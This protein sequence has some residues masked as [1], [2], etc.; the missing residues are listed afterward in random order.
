MFVAT[1]AIVGGVVGAQAAASDPNARDY[2][3]GYAAGHAAGYDVGKK[4]GGAILLGTLGVSAI[5]S[6]TIPFTGVL[7][8]CRRKTQP[9]PLPAI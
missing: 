2:K 1:L 9:P 8:W 5:A 4:Y 7:P 3:S 6:V